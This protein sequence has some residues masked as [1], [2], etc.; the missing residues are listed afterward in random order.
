MTPEER[1][2]AEAK[3]QKAIE[4]DQTKMQ[5]L[6]ESGSQIASGNMPGEKPTPK[7]CPNCGAGTNGGK[8]CSYCGNAL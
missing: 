7:F 2:A 4:E 1:A 5:D 8:F 3:A 6:L